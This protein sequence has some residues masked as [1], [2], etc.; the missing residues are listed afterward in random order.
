MLF[1]EDKHTRR[2]AIRIIGNLAPK[3]DSRVIKML[4]SSI[5]VCM[6]C[7][8]KSLKDTGQVGLNDEDEIAR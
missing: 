6:T 3:G 5:D 8:V 4:T 2:R 7:W 1:D